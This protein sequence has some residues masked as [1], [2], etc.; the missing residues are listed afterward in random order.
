MW[1]KCVNLVTSYAAVEQ[2]LKEALRLIKEKK[3]DVEGMITHR[4]PLVETQK[5]F[6][7]VINPENSM[8]VIIYPN[9]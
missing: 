2:D 7:L 3:V 8:K 4:L 5:G 6:E 9:K 1:S